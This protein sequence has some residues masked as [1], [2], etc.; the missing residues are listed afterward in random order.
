[1]YLLKSSVCNPNS[2]KPSLN[3]S[4]ILKFSTSDEVDFSSLIS[5]LGLYY[6]D[7]SKVLDLSYYA[8]FDQVK[9]MQIKEEYD[10]NL[11]SALAGAKIPK[12]KMKYWI[13]KIHQTD[14][15][16]N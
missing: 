9:R 3:N 1:M 14:K 16:G 12:N 4:N 2:F 10:T 11:K 7:L 8:F 13:R 5:S 6:R 15:G